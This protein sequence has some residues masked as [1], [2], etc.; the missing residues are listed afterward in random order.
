MRPANQTERGPVFFCFAAPTAFSGQ[1][2][3]TEIVVRGL[4]AR[5]W[6]CRRLPQP[7]F[8]RGRGGWREVLGFG[9]RLLLAWVRSLRMLVTPHGSLCVNLGQTRFA[10]VRDA[11][12]LLVGRLAF[13]RRRTVVSLHGSLF[14][15]WPDGSWDVILFRCLLRQAGL[16]TVLGERQRSRLQAL[17]LEARRLAIVVNSCSLPPLSGDEL[18]EKQATAPGKPR[19][20]RLLHL[21]SLIATKGFPEYL[22]A[23]KLLGN[24]QGPPVEAV[25][26]GRIIP[27]EFQDRFH[28][29]P[30]AVAW[31][32]GELAAIN[33][34]QRVRVHWIQGAVGAEK[35]ALFRAAELPAL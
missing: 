25:L 12:P 19:P 8:E 22:E 31:I 14:M 3:A 28:D 15:T 27:S 32:E 11:V 24:Q 5:G 30:T 34:S 7:V 4:A 20:V 23:L 21:S 10:F 29:E 6:D 35:A 1:K 2:E 17:G 26:C 9:A 13:G 18:Q 33:C 16:V